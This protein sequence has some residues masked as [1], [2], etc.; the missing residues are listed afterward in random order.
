MDLLLND[1]SF[2]VMHIPDRFIDGSRDGIQMMR[3]VNDSSIKFGKIYRGSNVNDATTT[4]KNYIVQKMKIGLDVDLRTSNGTDY[5]GQRNRQQDALNLGNITLRDANDYTGHAIEE[6]DGASTLENASNMKATLTRIF[7]AVH[8]NTNVYIHCM[9]G[10]DRTGTVCM[11]LEALL[12]VQMNECDK[13]FELTSFS[14]VGTRACDGS[15]NTPPQYPTVL[16]DINNSSE[17]GSGD[18]NTKVYNYCVNHYGISAQAI[19]Q[20]RT[21][22]L[23]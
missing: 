20:F 4:Q 10:A 15:A 17:A 12:G 19:Q 11:I 21:D 16:R 18:F 5:Q 7:N 1:F 2:K 13:D 3:V 9:V 8:N 14:V 6:Y 22:M 23:E